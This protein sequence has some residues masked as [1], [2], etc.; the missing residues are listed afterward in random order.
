MACVLCVAAMPISAFA[1]TVTT[2]D[3]FG[4]IVDAEGNV[5]ETL[6]MP[7]ATY[8]NSVFVIPAG[9]SLITYQ[10][11]PLKSFLFGLAT[12]DV[13]CQTRITE[14]YRDF[15]L[16]VEA[17]DKIGG[18]NRVSLG[19]HPVKYSTGGPG[20]DDPGMCIMVPEDGK[21][22]RYYNGKVVN[23]SSLSATVRIFVVLSFTNDDIINLLT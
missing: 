2:D 21:Y 22:F 3:L 14:P 11:E 17:S 5:V 12:T 6:P 19:A 7:R 16:S 8:L 9:G 18:N 20:Y 15:E 10:Y 1:D 23:K 4:V 13:D